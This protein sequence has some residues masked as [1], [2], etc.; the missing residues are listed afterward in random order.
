[1]IGCLKWY[2]YT[3]PPQNWLQMA[4]Y[5]VLFLTKQKG[6]KW[7]DWE[8]FWEHHLALTGFQTL[9]WSKLHDYLIQQRLLWQWV[10]GNWSFGHKELTTMI[11]LSDDRKTASDCLMPKTIIIELGA[12]KDNWLARTE[13]S[14][15][16]IPPRPD[17][18]RTGSVDD[19]SGTQ[20]YHHTL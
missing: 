16:R 14:W 10:S 2:A 17:I 15:Q 5:L 19:L 8:W 11:Y 18:R 3:R 13:Y 7:N 9:V 1:M 12:C 4:C 6:D 20:W